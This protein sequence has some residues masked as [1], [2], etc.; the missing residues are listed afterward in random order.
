MKRY[1]AMFFINKSKLS[2]IKWTILRLKC[3]KKK[4]HKVFLFYFKIR[5]VPV[6]FGS[7]C[8]SALGQ[9]MR[10]QWMP[11][12]KPNFNINPDLNPDKRY[13]ACCTIALV[14]KQHILKN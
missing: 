7:S 6:V 14:L 1:F 9:S 12:I 5:L 4:E 11:G 8:G 10:N 13:F 2:E 3:K